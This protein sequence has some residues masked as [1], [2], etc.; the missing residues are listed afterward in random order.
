MPEAEEVDIEIKPEDL[1]IEVCRAGGP[2]GQ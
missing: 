1:R 2:G